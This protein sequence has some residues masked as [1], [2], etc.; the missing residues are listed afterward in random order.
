MG[1]QAFRFH[2]HK[3]EPNASKLFRKRHQVLLHWVLSYLL[4]LCVPILCGVVMM[5]RADRMMVDE[6]CGISAQLQKALDQQINDQLD[7]L[8]STNDS[9]RSELEQRGLMYLDF[10]RLPDRSRLS[11]VCEILSTANRS[12]LSRNYLL[13]DRDNLLVTGSTVANCR[14]LPH[15]TDNGQLKTDLI[16]QLDFD[17]YKGQRNF[18]TV[19]LLEN[20]DSSQGRLML[21]TNL[22]LPGSGSARMTLFQIVDANALQSALGATLMGNIRCA[23]IVNRAGRVI[24]QAGDAPLP[25][26]EQIP[27]DHSDGSVR[28]QAS[29]KD[30]MAFCRPIAGLNGYYLYMAIPWR[31]IQQKSAALRGDIVLFV[32]I[33]MGMGLLLCT[34]LLRHNYRPLHSLS[35][36]VRPYVGENSS[37]DVYEQISETLRNAITQNDQWTS[38][39]AQ[40]RDTLT[41]RFMESALRGGITEMPVTREILASVGVTLEGELF[42]VLT[43]CPVQF[44]DG[45]AGQPLQPAMPQLTAIA[46]AL[47]GEIPFYV[48]ELDGQLAVLV[49]VSDDA[50]GTVQARIQAELTQRLAH[51]PALVGASRLYDSISLIHTCYQ[52]ATEQLQQLRAAYLR[53]EEVPLNRIAPKP[54]S[55][56][57]GFSVQQMEYLMNYLIS[58]DCDRAGAY[59]NQIHAEK[60]APAPEPPYAGNESDAVIRTVEEALH[61]RSDL[62]A[63]QCAAISAQ[64][65]ALAGAEIRSGEAFRAVFALFSPSEKHLRVDQTQ[66]LIRSIVQCV[67]E[68][69]SNPDFNVSKLA[70]LLQMNLSYISKC[71]K[72]STGI[73]LLDYI[74][75]MRINEGK[76]LISEKKRTVSQ[77]AQMVGFENLNSFIRVFK[78]YESCT[79]GS[80]RGHENEE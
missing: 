49:N 25:D 75:R 21:V 19:C 30:Y 51:A 78:K 80:I 16:D 62:G 13:L 42:G 11:G 17:A 65:D 37:G 66:P 6:Y 7:A 20:A 2:K 35:Q 69:Y 15:M 61:A 32:A 73:G 10:S 59:L 12:G 46:Q 72:V 18:Q 4:V 48:L 68:N 71:F 64:L 60:Y 55:R 53:G 70:E 9:V 22:P 5:N 67:E 40:Q 39:W 47:R 52:E 3:T 76:R 63:E 38:L 54:D 74:N 29:G 41:D 8:K 56:S 36:I 27:F 1:I 14:L 58:G 57:D 33:S 23:A 28:L 44:A 77:V 79:P 26:P 50:R 31:A 43:F 34:V 24:A 45:S